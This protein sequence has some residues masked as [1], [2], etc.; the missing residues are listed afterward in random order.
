MLLLHY[1]LMHRLLAANQ[2]TNS[3]YTLYWQ[4]TVCYNKCA[5]MGDYNVFAYM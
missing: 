2:I 1:S 3:L 5:N 4:A